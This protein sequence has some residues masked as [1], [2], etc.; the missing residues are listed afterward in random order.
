[1]AW[2]D[3]SSSGWKAYFVF[4]HELVTESHVWWETSTANNS[5][6]KEY[7]WLIRLIFR[8]YSIAKTCSLVLRRNIHFWR[9]HKLFYRNANI[10]IWKLK[11]LPREVLPWSNLNFSLTSY[12]Y[13]INLKYFW[14]I[15]KTFRPTLNSEVL[16]ISFKI[17]ETREHS[18]HFWFGAACWMDFSSNKLIK[19]HTKL[20]VW[21]SVLMKYSSRV[22]WPTLHVL[23]EV[24]GFWMA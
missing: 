13:A 10:I 21:N 5:Q 18:Y 8:F 2:R 7:D 1:M 4:P 24:E 9:D 3:D 20:P 12:F 11:L 15:G 22:S 19:K 23:L 16:S 14:K 6:E 17:N